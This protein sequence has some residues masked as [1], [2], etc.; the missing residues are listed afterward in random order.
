MTVLRCS[1]LSWEIHERG[2]LSSCLSYA[3]EQ[4]N[5]PGIGV[6]REGVSSA[7]HFLLAEA[8]FSTFFPTSLSHIHLAASLYIISFLPTVFKTFCSNKR[9]SLMG[10]SWEFSDIAK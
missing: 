6:I 10:K 5:A 7:F 3:L 1:N 8:Q 9:E 2:S 4:L